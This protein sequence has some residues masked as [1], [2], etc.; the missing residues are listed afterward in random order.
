MTSEPVPFRVPSGVLHTPGR[1]GQTLN[2][3]WDKRGTAWDKIAESLIPSSFM[4]DKIAG[5][6][7]TSLSHDPRNLWDKG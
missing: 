2:R 4:W 7:G 3:P 5:Q 1:V 6:R